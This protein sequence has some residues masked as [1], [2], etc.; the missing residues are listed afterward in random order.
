M[1]MSTICSSVRQ[2]G[3]SLEDFH[4]LTLLL[5]TTPFVDHNPPLA[6]ESADVSSG[7]NIDGFQHRIWKIK[8]ENSYKLCV[9][10]IYL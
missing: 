4:P 8:L 5:I 7:N 3:R 2:K 6:S 1:R 9:S 10:I